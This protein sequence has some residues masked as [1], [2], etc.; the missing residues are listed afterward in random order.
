MYIYRLAYD[1]ELYH[2]GIMGMKWGVRRYQN[3]DGSLTKEGR[4]RYSVGDRK[5]MKRIH[6]EYESEVNKEINKR[7]LDIDQ[8]YP[9]K[10][11][12]DGVPN[13]VAW[14]RMVK[15][16][17][18]YVKN[19]L[20]KKYGSEIIKDIDRYESDSKYAVGMAALGTMMITLGGLTVWSF[21]QI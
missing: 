11:Y 9:D 13:D 8:Y 4:F 14:D 10:Y 6:K 20:S 3:P 15:S 1:N 7:S 5:T 2:H 16:A 18:K 21:T 19:N 12:N 17:E